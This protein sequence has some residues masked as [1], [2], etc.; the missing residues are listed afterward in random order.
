LSNHPYVLGGRFTV[1]DLNIAVMMSLV[2]LADIALGSY[3]AMKTWL[4]DCLE[5]PNIPPQPTDQLHG[6]AAT[7]RANARE[8]CLT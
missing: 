5:H 4:H 8:L 6:S 3:L 1:A 2:P 7:C